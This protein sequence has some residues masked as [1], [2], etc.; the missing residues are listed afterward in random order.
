[1]TARGFAAARV[2]TCDP[3]R[4]TALGTVENGAVVF[5][6]GRIAFVGARADAPSGVVLEDLGQRVITPGLIDAHTHACWVGSRHAEYAMRMAGRSYGEIARA[7][8]GILSTHRA[9]TAA[10]E[11]ELVETLVLRLRRMASLGTTT[12]EVKSGYGLDAMQEKK[13]LAAIR[14]AG[15][16]NDAPAV[17]PTLLA[18]H[19]LPEEAIDRSEYVSRVARE[20]VPEVASQG[21]ARFVDAYVDANAFTVAEAYAV[22]KAARD[23]GLGVRL[24]VGQFADVGGAELGAELGA[25]SVDHLEHVSRPAIDALVRARVTGVLL[26]V[27]SFSLAQAAP[28]IAMMRDAGLE[29]VVASDAN[30]GTAPTES[31]PLAMALAVRSYGLSIAEAILGATRNAA[32]A[33]QLTDRG[34][35]RVGSRA[36]LT[37]WDLPSEEAIVQPWG[38]SKVYRVLVEGREI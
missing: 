17:V 28:P 12:V 3:A 2:V 32:A 5:E 10:S 6:R 19:A 38:V 27:A 15:S 24:H 29:L 37:L 34:V 30:P 35:L 36:D 18:L 4:G 23:A 26:P 11:D 21:L 13:Q 9:V 7:G 8:G 33:L 31:L 1:M 16:R 22:G 20:L 25:A 14:R